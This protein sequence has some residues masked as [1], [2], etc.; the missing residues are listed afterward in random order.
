M[1]SENTRNSEMRS[2]PK[3]RAAARF[4]PLSELRD[5]SGSSTAATDRAKALMGKRYRI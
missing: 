3:R 1:A 5:S 2:R 4:R